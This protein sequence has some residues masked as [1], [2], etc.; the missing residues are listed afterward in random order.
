MAC[1]VTSNL[2]FDKEACVI[3]I[4]WTKPLCE[5]SPVKD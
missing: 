5:N 4:E 3:Q 1:C 2:D